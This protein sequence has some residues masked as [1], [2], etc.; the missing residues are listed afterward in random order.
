MEEQS[1][2][3][4]NVLQRIAEG[5]QAA[6]AELFRRY[7]D[8]LYETLYKY[9][10]R[11]IDTEDIVQATFIK[12]W[13]KRELFRE[14]KNPM[15]WLFIMARNEYLDRLRRNRLSERYRQ[16]ITE[17]FNEPDTSPESIFIDKEYDN[18][19]RQAISLL[20]EKQKQAFLL[21]REAG[22]TY[23]E[24]ADQMSIEKATVKVHIARALQSIRTYLLSQTNP[25]T[26]IIL[27]LI[28]F[29]ML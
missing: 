18:L 9:T 29:K 28:F 3:E 17:L 5:D 25:K 12:A 4:L 10:Q 21:S 22:L 19:Y 6:F 11:H 16:H 26:D 23:E 27:L 8:K 14:M 15:S 24:I 7:F 20:P 1:Y 13:E 2:N